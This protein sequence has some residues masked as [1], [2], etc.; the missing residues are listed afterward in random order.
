MLEFAIASLCTI[1]RV[2]DGDT[3]IAN[4]NNAEIRVR[5]CGIDSPELKQE[6]GPE[7]KQFVEK[8]IEEHGG[9]VS[10]VPVSVDL[11]GRIVAEIFVDPFG[12][13]LLVQG[14]SLRNGQSYLYVQ[15]LKSCP[16]KD[17]MIQESAIAQLERRGVFANQN[18]IKP[19]EFR[20]NK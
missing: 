16:S 2:I 20:Q 19:W 12:I 1:T 8:L 3:V 17:L 15:Y 11:Y 7:S 9:Q 10:L 4:C 5:M 18:A 14:E 6:G 13:P